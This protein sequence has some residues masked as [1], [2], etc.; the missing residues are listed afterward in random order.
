MLTTKTAVKS[1]KLWPTL[2]SSDEPSSPGFPSY[3]GNQ[4]V[5]HVT[6]NKSMMATPQSSNLLEEDE[7]DDDEEEKVPVY[8]NNLGEAL[9]NALAN[10]AFI[11]DPACRTK[12]SKNKKK[13][14]KTILFASGMNFN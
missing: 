9:A 11:S 4:K 10:S 8:N 12:G 14:K 2:A 1:E 7:I 6:G 5:T 3:F 13:T